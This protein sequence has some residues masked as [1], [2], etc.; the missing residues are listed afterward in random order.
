MLLF[1][2][3]TTFD[4]AGD[5]LMKPSASA[6]PTLSLP[7][8][9]GVDPADL[10]VIICS[11]SNAL[12][13]GP[14]PVLKAALSALQP[15]LK[16]PVQK[17]LGSELSLSCISAG[18]LILEHVATCSPSQQQTLLKWLDTAAR[19]VQVISVTEPRLFELVE[20]GCFSDRLYYR[21]NTIH[22]D[23][24]LPI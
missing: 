15:H 21:L 16:A 7:H 10:E 9:R 5:A 19:Q 13:C 8:V 3:A 20:R 11:G 1:A 17:L 6:H 23:F 2:A 22:L 14:L 18:T 24:H 4:A 12:L